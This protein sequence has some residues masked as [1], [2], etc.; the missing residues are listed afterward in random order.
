MEN[1]WSN[2]AAMDKLAFRTCSSAEKITALAIFTGLMIRGMN[3]NSL[4]LFG[5]KLNRLVCIVIVKE[6]YDSSSKL[7]ACFN[8]IK[9]FR[10]M[11]LIFSTFNYI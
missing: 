3:L 1:N 11:V 7:M 8:L 6:I 2:E 10:N 9:C 4:F 5:S